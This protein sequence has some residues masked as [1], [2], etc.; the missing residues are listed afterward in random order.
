MEDIMLFASLK[1][2]F[3]LHRV[4]LVA[5]MLTEGAPN[6]DMFGQPVPL[7]FDAM[8]VPVDGLAQALETKLCAISDEWEVA[9]RTEPPP[10]R[11]EQLFERS[12]PQAV[13]RAFYD[14][15]DAFRRHYDDGVSPISYILLVAPNQPVRDALSAFFASVRAELAGLSDEPAAAPAS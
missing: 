14:G 15:I 3:G 2:S 12:D 8:G 1:G 9:P 7:D 5:L 13:A 6:V 4:T 10:L 11:P